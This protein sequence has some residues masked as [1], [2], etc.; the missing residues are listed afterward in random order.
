MSIKLT[1]QWKVSVKSKEAAFDQRVVIVGTTNGQDGTYPYATFGTK[2]LKGS[3]GI[4]VQYEKAGAWHDSLMRIGNVSRPASELVVEIES[5]DNVGQGDLDF[6]DLILEAKKTVADDDWCL[7][8]QVKSYQGCIFNPCEL[9][10]LVID[11]WVHVAER[12]PRDIRFKLEPLLPELPPIKFPFP[13]PPPPPPWDYRAIKMEIPSELAPELL[14]ERTPGVRRGAFRTPGLNVLSN[15]GSEAFKAAEAGLKGTTS[16]FAKA[17]MHLFRCHVEPA[18]GVGI[19]IIEY[20]PGPGESEGGPFYGTGHRDVKGQV[21]TDDWGFYVF[22]FKWYASAA[23]TGRPDVMLQLVK[24]SDEGVP[25]VTLESSV[26]WNISNLYRKDFCIPKHLLEPSV[27][28]IIDPARIFQY[29][30]NLPVARIFAGAGAE[31]GHGTSQPGDLVSV[32]RAPFGGV[33]YLKGSFHNFPQVKFYRIKYATSDCPEGN[34][35]L[36][37]LMTPLR[38]YDATFDLVTVGPGPGVFP[39][40]PADA[41]PNMEGN[42]AYSHPFGDRY[43]AYINTGFMK[44]G[45]LHIHI[46]G[47]DSAGNPVSGAG[48]WLTLRIDNV[49]PVPE[50][51]PITEGAEVGAGCG[52]I[53]IQNPNDTFPLTYRVI[54]AEGHLYRYYFS[55]YKCHNNLV[56][57]TLQYDTVYQASWPLYWHGTLDEPGLTPDLSGWVTR[58]MPQTGKLF[59]SQEIADGI[60]F[61]AF[62]IELWAVS[63]S[64]DGRHSHLH[65]PRYV[66]VIGVNYVPTTP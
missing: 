7:W 51:Q 46:Q 47:L 49:A 54:D 2:T 58:D 15:P 23:G 28:G 36:T 20:D 37:T 9:P 60:T 48:D 33:L 50:I 14:H 39:G 13:F 40:V 3:F 26:S 35:G 5:D 11:D 56:G 44:T 31:R 41:Y 18:S 12:L 16:L 38:Y 1:G 24:F 4:Q 43:K 64:T 42:Y 30:G 55:I 45:Y 29:V 65:W 32:D 62:S 63:R 25:S 53:T 27:D 21:I 10:R 59:T 22:C 19:R 61:G 66:E 34:V 17:A 6:N 57:N 8:G 52:L